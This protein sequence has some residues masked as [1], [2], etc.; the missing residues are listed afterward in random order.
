MR[1]I[2][3]QAEAGLRRTRPSCVTPRAD[4][5]LHRAA[6]LSNRRTV[7]PNGISANGGRN[8]EGLGIVH[9]VR[10]KS[11]GWAFDY[12]LFS[13]HKIEDL[14][15]ATGV[16]G[17]HAGEPMSARFDELPLVQA[18]ALFAPAFAFGDRLEL[19]DQLTLNPI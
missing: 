14:Y 9:N 3:E 16:V 2:P 10:F 15:S 6:L 12:G 8:D 13:F 4:E 19:I 5:S 11:A 18:C 17:N 1:D 7:G